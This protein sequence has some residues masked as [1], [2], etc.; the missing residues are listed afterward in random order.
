MSGLMQLASQKYHWSLMS[1]E[2]YKKQTSGIMN[3]LC[4]ASPTNDHIVNR[5]ING[6]Q[7][8]IF[9]VSNSN[10]LVSASLIKNRK[11]CSHFV[12]ND[13]VEQNVL[14]MQGPRQIPII[15]V[16]HIAP[17]CVLCRCQSRYSR[18]NGKCCITSS[19]SSNFL[20]ELTL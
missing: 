5:T 7:P 10:Y 11:N 16:P 1:D 15:V 4:M 2:E 17:V 14:Q 18:C 3:F 9:F 6:S 8:H 13:L 19:V 20:R 12:S